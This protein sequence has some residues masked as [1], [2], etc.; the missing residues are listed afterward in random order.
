MSSASLTD[1]LGKR[2]SMALGLALVAPLLVAM[3]H[4]GDHRGLA[5]GL[6]ALTFLGFE[7]SI[8]SGIPL[9][10]EID[11]EAR[12][13]SIGATY[14]SITVAR[15]FGAAC[16]VWLFT[17]EGMAWTSSIGAAITVASIAVILGAE[18]PG[19]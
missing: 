10:A 14:A 18:E 12:S 6:L 17:H 4:V 3:G 13:R 7:F 19:R 1:R 11:P 8:V 9:A 2:R 16:G 15:A 5:I